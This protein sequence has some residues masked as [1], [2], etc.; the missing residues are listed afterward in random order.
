[1]TLLKLPW[2]RVWPPVLQNLK[3][4]YWQQLSPTIISLQI[5][6]LWLKNLHF[7][8]WS[9]WKW[10]KKKEATIDNNK[11]SNANLAGQIKFGCKMKI[12]YKPGKEVSVVCV[13]NVT[14]ISKG[15]LAAPVCSFLLTKWKENIHTKLNISP[16]QGH[17]W[18]LCL[19]MHSLN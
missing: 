7:S 15:Y 4:I 3:L 16:L 1:M 17:I 10:I 8:L 5:K 13:C 19:S 14:L 18:Q 9:K 11:Q 2:P 6:N 12:L